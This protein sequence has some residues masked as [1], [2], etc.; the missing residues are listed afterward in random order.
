M[1]RLVFLWLLFF[2]SQSMFGQELSSADSVYTVVDV[3][4]EF[5]GGRPALLKYITENIHYPDDVLKLSLS[6]K[7]ILKF[8]VNVDGSLTDIRVVKG[9]T[10]FPECDKEAVRVIKSMPNWIPAKLNG[11]IV[12]SY[13]ILPISI[14]F[15]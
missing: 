1:M 3:S 2:V 12:R 5:P 10:E 14:H 9:M 8:V 7:T 15:Q 11:E 4:A 6:G 13:F